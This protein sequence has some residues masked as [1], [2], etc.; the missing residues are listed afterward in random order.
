M[1]WTRALTSVNEK[2]IAMQLNMKLAFTHNHGNYLGNIP[3]KLYQQNAKCISMKH[4][5]NTTLLHTLHR[6]CAA[7]RRLTNNGATATTE[8]ATV[9]MLC[10]ILEC[11]AHLATGAI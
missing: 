2:N 6:R 7:F 9:S 3:G 5:E 4:L 11:K 8:A 1:F 10:R